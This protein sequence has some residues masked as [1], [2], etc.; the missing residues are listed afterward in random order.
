MSYQRNDCDMPYLWYVIRGEG[1]PGA[2]LRNRHA[3]IPLA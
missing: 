3:D 2:E 1:D